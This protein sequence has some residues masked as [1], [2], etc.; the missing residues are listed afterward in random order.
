LAD[1]C[2]RRRFYNVPSFTWETEANDTRSCQIHNDEVG[3][4]G[5]SAR[6]PQSADGVILFVGVEIKQ[7]DRIQESGQFSIKTGDEERKYRRLRVGD[8]F[9]KGQIIGKV[10]DAMAR[11]EERVMRAKVT[12]SEA[13][14]A[15][16][17]KIRDEAGARFK[18]REKRWLDPKNE[19]SFE[20]LKGFRLTF[21]RCASEARA[22]VEAVKI[23][24]LQ[25]E[26]ARII[27]EMHQIHSGVRGIVRKF[28][29]QPGDAVKALE[30]IVTLQIVKDDDK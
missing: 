27:I 6:N 9:E 5:R 10:D 16:S 28:H 29:K 15:A 24:K 18:A 11:A 20:E 17:E 23:A 2:F 26:R 4:V 14:L 1:R 13:A 30:S 19:S 21:F 7:G 22:Q 25:L 12:T 3:M 8:V